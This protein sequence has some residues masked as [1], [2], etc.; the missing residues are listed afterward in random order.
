MMN[1]KQTHRARWLLAAVVAAA[2]PVVMTP[3]A[4][5]QSQ[6]QV[7]GRALDANNR[8]GS[9]GTNTYRPAPTQGV[10]GNNIINGNV[11]GG[12]GFRGNVDYFDPNAFHGFTPGRTTDGFVKDSAAV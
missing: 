2:M 12:R 8:I 10:M 5:G 6:Q 7:D 3:L 4:H 9:G 11:S 1:K